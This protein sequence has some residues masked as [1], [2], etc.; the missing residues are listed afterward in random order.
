MD[1]LGQTNNIPVSREGFTVAV[2]ELLSRDGKGR[3][4]HGA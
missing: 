3:F 1:I 2:Q 4:R